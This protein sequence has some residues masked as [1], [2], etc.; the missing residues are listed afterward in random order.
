M[1]LYFLSR[2]KKIP[3][4]IFLITMSSIVMAQRIVSGNILDESKNPVSG[5]TVSVK[6]TTRQALTNDKGQFSIEAND[7]DILIV[8]HVSFFPLEVKASQAGT[9]SLASNSRS[10]S[11]VVVTATGIK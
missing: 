1:L 6:G 5:A 8:S 7:G 10:L 4:V 2:C 9:I 3:L 11:E